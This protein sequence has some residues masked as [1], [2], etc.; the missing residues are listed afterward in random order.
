MTTTNA[1]NGVPCAEP[2]PLLLTGVATPCTPEHWNRVR[3]LVRD[4]MTW[5]EEGTG[6]KLMDAQHDTRTEMESLEEYYGRPNGQFLVGILDGKIVGTTGV[7]MLEPGV[8]ELRRVYV[9]PEARGHGIAPM[10]LRSAI[11]V[12]E[13][14]G[15]TC[16]RLETLPKLMDDAVRMYR[17]AG[18]T[19]IPSDTPGLS[20]HPD[21]LAMELNLG[22]GA[23]RLA[24]AG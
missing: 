6:I 10:M 15:A 19:P 5:I 14:M 17:K 24:K 16:V 3:A 7:R 20:N 4:L 18:F 13:Q 21:V 1:R 9:A 12:A 2:A 22:E 23:Q 11:R 8:A